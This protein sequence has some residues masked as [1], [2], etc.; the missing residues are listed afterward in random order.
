MIDLKKIVKSVGCNLDSKVDYIISTL[1]QDKKIFYGDSVELF[2]Y[3]VKR[4]TKKLN[5]KNVLPYVEPEGL[6]IPVD[7]SS[8]YISSQ[9]IASFSNALLP[10]GYDSI[11]IELPKYRQLAE[12]SND[13]AKLK[14]I[15]K[16]EELYTDTLSA[17]LK[18]N[19]ANFIETFYRAVDTYINYG[20]CMSHL[21]LEQDSEGKEY[22]R[23]NG[24]AFDDLCIGKPNKHGKQ[25]LMYKKVYSENL[26][27]DKVQ[28]Y[29]VYIPTSD[30]IE[31]TIR[32]EN[33]PILQE[34]NINN[35]S[36]FKIT[37]YVNTYKKE[38]RIKEVEVYK[39]KEIFYG[40]Y[41][42]EEESYS[43]GAGILGLGSIM[44]A[45]IF[46][47]AKNI[48]G[49][50]ALNPATILAA[51]AKTTGESL[52]VSSST[53][54]GEPKQFKFK[55]GGIIRIKAEEGSTMSRDIQTIQP[56]YQT[57]EIFNAL[58]NDA[59]DQ[60]GKAYYSE[61]FTMDSKPNETAT[62]V[63]Q[64]RESNIRIFNGVA[65]G[66]YSNYLI[67][68]LNYIKG[69]IDVQME[70]LSKSLPE[71]TQILK[72]MENILKISFYEDSQIR[73]SNFETEQQEAIRMS[74]LQA[75]INIAASI[76]QITNTPPSEG[77]MRDIEN[78]Y[79]K[80]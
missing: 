65:T 18:N 56:A 17:V 69:F 53:R 80:I 34:N 60:I 40:K 30:L 75:K 45:N 54:L 66:F 15:T 57:L 49:S 38:G 48:A 32:K 1:I 27:K 5:N 4:S 61:L 74:K 33:I 12:T 43:K 31:E 24:V 64:R 20:V 42:S 10:K 62:A 11:K 44:Q 3:Y 9:S 78:M 36:Y 77:M 51:A 37:I 22:F 41:P 73:I 71:E 39:N 70:L 47:N 46:Y 14:A 26:E 28:E 52:N 35:D 7:T 67:P 2:Q 23:F 13:S 63:I 19:K 58:Y 6:L 25:I 72:D 16:I 55:A 29:V 50:Q 8:I 59:V 76:S 68:M 79:Y 21:T